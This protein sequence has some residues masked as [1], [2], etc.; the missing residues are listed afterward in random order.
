MNNKD[1]LHTRSYFDVFPF[2]YIINMLLEVD[3]DTAP[4]PTVRDPDIL[5]EKNTLFIKLH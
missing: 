2:T 1:Q 5:E 3:T 4:S